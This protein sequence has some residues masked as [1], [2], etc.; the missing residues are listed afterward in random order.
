MKTDRRAPTGRPTF[1]LV[2]L[3]LLSTVVT[4]ASCK[5]RATTASGS[6]PAAPGGTK[7]ATGR[8]LMETVAPAVPTQVSELGPVPVRAGGPEKLSALEFAVLD[9]AADTAVM[10]PTCF[11]GAD[12]RT[13]LRGTC[14]T[15][16]PPG[17]VVFPVVRAPDRNYY[18]NATVDLLSGG[19]WRGYATFGYEESREGEEFVLSLVGACGDAASL[20]ARV[21]RSGGVE[22]LPQ[23]PQDAVIL[24][25]VPVKMGRPCR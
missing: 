8:G 2:C 7:Q 4:S 18:V 1:R 11:Q 23:L 3:V 21:E 20:F 17:C 10:H 24:A 15:S 5:E 9:P 6:A 14:S 13:R 16:L 12:R 25:A 19:E 22:K